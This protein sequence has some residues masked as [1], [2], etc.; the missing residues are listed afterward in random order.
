MTS[1]AL[2]TEAKIYKW[3]YSKPK[4]LCASKDT[5]TRVKIQLM[6]W[7]KIFADHI[8]DKELIYRIYKE[9]LQLSN[10]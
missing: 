5:V 10:K 8:S 6:E 2:A 7:E 1:K 4:I 9:F 3:D